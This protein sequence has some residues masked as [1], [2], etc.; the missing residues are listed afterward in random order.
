MY[1]FYSFDCLIV[2]LAKGNFR[3]PLSFQA[4]LFI[5]PLQQLQHFKSTG[6]SKQT[7]L[8]V[9]SLPPMYS[10]P[11]GWSIIFSLFSSDQ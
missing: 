5:F 10:L 1:I 9:L 3:V 6:N 11:A 4:C 7:A 2:G 8:L